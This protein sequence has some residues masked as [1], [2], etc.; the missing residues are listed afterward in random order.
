MNSEGDSCVEINVDEDQLYYFTAL[1]EGNYQTLFVGWLKRDFLK[2]F[3]VI[4]GGS[5]FAHIKISLGEHTFITVINAPLYLLNY[6]NDKILEF[7]GDCNKLDLYP[8]GNTLTDSDMGRTIDF[9]S[10]FTKGIEPLIEF[11]IFNKFWVQR[12]GAWVPL[13]I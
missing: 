10:Y 6:E 8:S 5:N 1:S 13:N 7:A 3:E 2:A 11:K 4:N 12:E 9:P